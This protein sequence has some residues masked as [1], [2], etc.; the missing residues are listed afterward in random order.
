VRKVTIRECYRLIGFPDDFRLVGSKAQLYNRIGNSIVIPMVEEIAQ[1]IKKQF[2][3]SNS[4][5]KL[6]IKQ[7]CLFDF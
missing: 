3:W 2:F 6:Q 7:L 1:Q 5:A 4:P